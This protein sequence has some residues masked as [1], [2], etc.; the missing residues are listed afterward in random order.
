MKKVPKW[1]TGSDSRQGTLST[2]YRS[3]RILPKAPRLAIFQTTDIY[4]GFTP[5]YQVHSFLN[6][7]QLLPSVT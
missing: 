6:Q 2:Q 3:Q 4:L 5:T 1:T 7:A